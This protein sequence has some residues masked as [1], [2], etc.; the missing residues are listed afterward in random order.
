MARPEEFKGHIGKTLAESQAYFDEPPHAPAGAPDVVFIVLDDTGFAQLGCYGSD[1]ATPN[2]D[3]LAISGVQFTN[4]HA[5][6]LC[7]PTRAA[8]LTG[9]EP[10]AVGMRAI[11]NFRTGF[12]HMLGHISY[13]AAT[14]AEVLHDNGYATFC[15]GKWHLAPMVHC[16]AGGPFEHWPLARGFDRFYGFLEG[17]T[18][19]FAPQLIADN[20]PVEQPKTADE[21]YHLSED[22]VDQALLMISNSVGVLPDKRFFCYL[23]FGAMHAPHQ[24]P[25]EYLARYRGAFDEGWD[26]ARERW[27]Q[28]QIETGVLPPD[29]TLAPR[30]PGVEAWD[31][32]TENQRRLAARMQE[33]FAA[34]LTHTD[35]QIGRLI[36]GLE[37]LGRLDNTLIVLVSDNGASQ[38]GGPFGVMHEMK[39]FNG[40]LEQPDEAIAHLDDIGGP[41][42]HTNY[43]WGWAQAGNTPYRW[44]KQNTHEGGIRVPMI[45][46]WANGIEETQRGLRD[47]FAFISDIAP[48]VYELIGIE[49]PS[50]RLGIDQL[51]VTGHS[52]ASILKDRHAATANTEQVFEMLGSRALVQGDYKAVCKHQSGADF[53][54]EP[55]ELYD[56]I[57]DRSECNDLADAL[58]DKLSELK[59]R[60]WEL[61]EVRGILP[62]DDRL[63]ELFGTNFA[64]HTPHRQ[65]RR[66]VYRPPMHPMS[67]QAGAP[68]GGRDF[69]IEALATLDIDSQGTIYAT[70]TG[71]SGLTFFVK[72]SHLHFD[73]N[74]FGDHT[75][76]TS[77]SKIEPGER[78]LGLKVRRTGARTANAA[79]FVDGS[80]VGEAAL[81]LFMSIISSVGPA[82]GQNPGS[83]VSEMYEPP[84]VFDGRLHE[85]VIQLSPGK[86]AVQND[87]NASTQ[88][89]EM[90]RQ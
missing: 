37:R 52:F 79:I 83:A 50:Q 12:P 68:I 54:T 49:P 78:R 43:P 80:M 55:W 8:L 31:D 45:T 36:S 77:T 65:D 35:D 66:Y 90:S 85:V 53:M 75:V 29:T 67:S 46:S 5:T 82:V 59:S 15:V 47:Q 7:S 64:D 27:H 61:A 4:F 11:S 22:L 76:L 16:S 57:E 3:R 24:A 14:T 23:A 33:A 13:R 34:F 62:L 10:H 56:L 60:W 39:F 88:R 26:K 40:I 71:N 72:D 21:G 89:A 6:P 28:R 41:K 18:D 87:D 17:E 38:E 58:P 51:P 20:H 19:Q 44:Y 70:G 69:D 42:S 63:I 1:I 32:L 86:Y 9:R 30:N 81:P 73:Y 84:F 48:T 2:I 74:A 25:A